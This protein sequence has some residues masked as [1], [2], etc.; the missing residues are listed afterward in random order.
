[1]LSRK[2]VL[3]SLLV[4]VG[5][6]AVSGVGCGPID[7]G[8]H[9][10]GGGA[11]GGKESLCVAGLNSTPKICT[12]KCANNAECPFGYDCAVSDATQGKTCNKT[13][14]LTDKVSGD[15]LLFGKSCAPGDATAAAICMGTG[16]PNPSPSCRVGNDP[17]Q[18]S[19]VPLASDPAANCTGSC[20]NDNDCPLPMKCAADFDGITK[21]LKRNVCDVCVYDE[22]CGEAG[23]VFKS[24]F[25]ACV[26]TT[27]KSSSYCSKPCAN[28]GDCPGASKKSTWMLCTATAD[29][30][31]NSGMFCTDWYGACVGMGNICDPCRSDSDCTAPGTKCIDNAYGDYSY[32]FTGEH[33][34]DKICCNKFEMLPGGY[35]GKCL[36]A[37]PD[38]NCAGPNTGITCDYLDPNTVDST[39]EI[40]PG[41]STFT[42]TNDPDHKHIGLFSCHI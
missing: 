23:G 34:C 14:Y 41:S 2:L 16:D 13:L 28:D 21:C 4:A 15:P 7:I 29:T 10:S 18:P 32:P 39:G 37:D 9:C 27:D 33:S 20:T 6:M 3:G 30:D 11:C 42:C 38:A 5:L 19:P 22:N 24:D 36:D 25:T 26:P 8:T 17:N 31:G 35:P 1:M 12:H 40:I